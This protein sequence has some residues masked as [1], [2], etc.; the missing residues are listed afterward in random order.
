METTVV[1]RG[2][3]SLRTLQANKRRF[4]WAQ[5]SQLT[6]IGR[7]AAAADGR[8]WMVAPPNSRLY[9]V[10]FYLNAGTGSIP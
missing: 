10:R 8:S 6:S 3:T 9:F 2:R 1:G 4:D 7:A 5:P